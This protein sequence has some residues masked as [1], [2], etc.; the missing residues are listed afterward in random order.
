MYDKNEHLAYFCF[1]SNSALRFLKTR[2]T[3]SAVVAAIAMMRTTSTATTPPMMAAVLS[4]P[5]S[6]VGIVGGVDTLS[7]SDAGGVLDTLSPSD[8]GAAI[9]NGLTM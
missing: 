4:E 5:D 9:I 6:G 2:A 1:S 8:A 7:P 3:I